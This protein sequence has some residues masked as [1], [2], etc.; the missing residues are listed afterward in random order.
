MGTRKS[1]QYQEP[2]STLQ[3]SSSSARARKWGEYTCDLPP[4][5]LD[6]MLGDIAERHPDI[7]WVIVTGVAHI[8][9]VSMMSWQNFIYA[10]FLQFNYFK[11]FTLTTHWFTIIIETGKYVQG[12]C[13]PTTFG[14]NPS[15]QIS[16]W[17]RL[18]LKLKGICST[19]IFQNLSNLGNLI[20][21]NP[22]LQR[23]LSKDL[24]RFPEPSVKRFISRL[25]PT[26]W[27]STSPRCRFFRRSGTTNRFPSTCSPLLPFLVS[28]II[29]YISGHR[30]CITCPL[31]IFPIVFG[32]FAP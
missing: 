13:R 12:T 6:R 17:Q 14:C 29:A 8:G 11:C 18:F 24:T 25:L 20:F 3:D 23:S 28:F 7:S 10:L 4:W 16:M 1:R 5:T 9:H 21:S 15:T 19:N 32:A 26:A 2:S 31:Q 22:Q 30:L 27:R